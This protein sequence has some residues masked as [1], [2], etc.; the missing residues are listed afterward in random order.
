VEAL[1]AAPDELPPIIVQHP[2]MRVIDG[3][4]RLLAARARGDKKILARFFYG[5]EAD[6]FVVAVRSNIAHGLPLSLTDR[7]TAAAR[8]ISSHQYWSD[9]WIASVT[10]LAANTVADIRRR[11][12]G[13]PAQAGV[14]VG[15]DGRVRPINGAEGRLLAYQL[16]TND[17]GLSLRKIAQAAGI[18]PE[19]ARDVRNRL[20]QGEDPVPKRFGK[21]AP[22]K[23]RLEARRPEIGHRAAGHARVPGRLIATVQR[24][25]ADPALRFTETGRR[26]LRLLHAQLIDAAEWEKIG[27]NVPP[28]CSFIIANLAQE[29]ADMWQE[30]AEQLERKMAETALAACRGISPR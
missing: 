21:K 11:G 4:H 17:P 14:R 2:T 24:L 12:G 27:E 9:R 13:A 22:K 28:H 5:D 3:V 6:A 20:R 7:R 16:M 30:L 8:I 29:C 15:Q 10:G 23:G 25:K 1:A 18:S 26:L 19:T